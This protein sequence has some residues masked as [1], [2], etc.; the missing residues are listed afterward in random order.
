MSQSWVGKLGITT[1][2]SHLLH[3]RPPL[4]PGGLIALTVRE[5]DSHQVGRA[6]RGA[7]G[8]GPLMATLCLR[9]KRRARGHIARLGH[10]APA[11]LPELHAFWG[12]VALLS[13]HFG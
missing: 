9:E 13:L 1:N 2:L 12:R 6:V 11:W 10:R 5:P 7:P 8:P 4:R 3:R